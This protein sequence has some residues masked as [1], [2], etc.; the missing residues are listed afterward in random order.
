M[1]MDDFDV[2]LRMEF[3]VEKGVIPI[4]SSESLLIMGEKPAMV[5]MK[6]NHA[7]DL[8]LL[9]MLQFKKGVKWQGPTF[10]AFSTVYEDEGGEHILLEIEV[11]LKKYGNVM[12]DQLPKTLPPRREIDHQIKLVLGAKLHASVPYRMVISS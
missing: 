7:T 4:P 11:V 8:Q 10:V 6:V 2:I 1:R 9:S 5:P 3:L 12:P